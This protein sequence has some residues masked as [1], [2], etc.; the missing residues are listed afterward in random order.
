[1][2][3]A[4]LTNVT[5]VKIEALSDERLPKQGPGR[6]NDGNF[7]L[8]ELKVSTATRDITPVPLVRVWDFSDDAEGWDS[9]NGSTMTAQDGQL[10]I[11]H[12]DSMQQFSTRVTAPAASLALEITAKLSRETNVRLVWQTDSDPYY[13]P[14]RSAAKQFSPGSATWRTYRLALHPK[15]PLHKVKLDFS[16][17]EAKIPI[18]SIRLV[19]VDAAELKPVKLQNPQADFSQDGFAVAEAIDGKLDKTNNGWAVAPKMGTNHEAIFEVADPSAR[20]GPGLIHTELVHNYTGGKHNLG[21]F[22]MS[23]TH[24]PQPID[25]GLPAEIVQILIVDNDQRSDPQRSQLEAYYIDQDKNYND[26]LTKIADAE[27]P[28]PPDAR[29]EQLKQRVAELSKPPPI[30][31]KLAELQ[32]A[33]ELSKQQLAQQRLT[34]AQDVAWALINSPEF[35]YNH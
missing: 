35:L 13:A 19:Q 25:F 2:A 32:R 23:I 11:E 3:P 26:Q 15:S 21:R 4:D 12:Q 5:G 28:L 1:V 8:T 29:T 27:K 7:V 9:Q 14:E 17:G 31:P 33:A 16:G 6:A 18:D 24:S 34:I 20:S 10:M 22:R 30:D